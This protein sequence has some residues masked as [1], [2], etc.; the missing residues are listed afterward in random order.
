MFIGLLSRQRRRSIIQRLNF[1]FIVTKI[2]SELCLFAR[3]QMTTTSCDPS[4]KHMR[5]VNYNKWD[6]RT[7]QIIALLD[8]FCVAWIAQL[9]VLVSV[10][11]S[12]RQPTKGFSTRRFY[13]MSHLCHEKDKWRNQ[14]LLSADYEELD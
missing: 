12:N 3:E 11:Q 8:F 10:I 14:V 4:G 6:N 5:K 7:E 1:D 2:V 13:L 9:C